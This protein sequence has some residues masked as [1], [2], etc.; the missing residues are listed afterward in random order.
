MHLDPFSWSQRCG[1]SD[2]PVQCGCHRR[3]WGKCVAIGSDVGKRSD[4]PGIGGC[5]LLRLVG[6]LSA[7]SCARLPTRRRGWSEG[8][9]QY[10]SGLVSED[11]GE[12]LRKALSVESLENAEAGCRWLLLLQQRFIRWWQRWIWPGTPTGSFPTVVLLIKLQRL[13]A[14][15]MILS[16]EKISL[17]FNY[18]KC[19]ILVIHIVL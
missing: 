10:C 1:W 14:L 6:G 7:R 4:H 8:L 9:A 3:I 11:T 2:S 18:Y 19:S 17:T 12:A 16:N 15:W 13:M 5:V